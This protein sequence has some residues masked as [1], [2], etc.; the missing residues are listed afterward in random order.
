MNDHVTFSGRESY[1]ASAVSQFNGLTGQF[2]QIKSRRH[3]C[4]CLPHSYYDTGAIVYVRVFK[5]CRN[6][7]MH[8]CRQ[9]L[10]CVK[11]T[12]KALN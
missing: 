3:R 4:N 12:G 7:Q 11:L 2:T 6:K 8:R 5:L 10:I 9:D 1:A